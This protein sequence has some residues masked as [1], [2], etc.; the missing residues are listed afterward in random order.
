[1]T[2]ATAA[3]STLHPR[4]RDP[5]VQDELRRAWSASGGSLRLEQL[6]APG[7]AATLAE[8]AL[9][10]FPFQ[11]FHLPAG[12]GPRGFFWRCVIDLAGERPE[13]PLDAAADFVL[14][15][16]PWLALAITGRTLRVPE[17]IMG[18]CSYVKGC[19]LDAHEDEWV[20]EHATAWVVGLTRDAWPEAEGGHL[21][22]LADDR[23]TPL[24]SR[25]PGWD[26]L[27]L[28]DVHPVSRWHAIP[29]L[30][31]HRERL[32]LSGL[33]TEQAAST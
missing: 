14:R 23:T 20:G 28:Y 15:D 5:A 19:Y 13:P 8:A 31:T 17:P 27:D 29:L 9:A 22:F 33:L 32:T 4:L 21:T 26:T 11:G 16:L 2:D 18:F 1:M 25:P 10:R 3:P 7:L 24:G 30:E 6:L 12:R